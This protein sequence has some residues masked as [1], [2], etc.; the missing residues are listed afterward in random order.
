MVGLRVQSKLFIAIAV[1]IVLFIGVILFVIKP[2]FVEKS[3]EQD[4]AMT[5]DQ[6]ESVSEVFANHRLM[7][8]R[9][10]V[11]WSV[12]TN[13]YDFVQNENDTFVEN[14]MGKETLEN[15]G[16]GA[17]I[18]L[19]KN[20]E[21][22]YSEFNQIYELE[23]AEE[24]SAFT[25]DLLRYVNSSSMTQ[26]AVYGTD[27]GP[28]V[29]MSHPIVKSDGTGEPSGTLVII[30]KIG[31]DFMAAMSA[32]AKTKLSI[33]PLAHQ[34][35]TIEQDSRFA[36][37]SLPLQSIYQ[38][39]NWEVN[40]SVKRTYYTNTQTMLETGMFGLLVLGLGLLLTLFWTV[41]Q[42]ITKRLMG[43]VK[44]LKW[45]TKERNSRLR[46]HLHPHKQDEIEE[47]AISMNEVLD[48]LEQ[49]Q[50]ESLTRAFR[51]S[52]TRLPNRL[53][54]EEMFMN[55]PDTTR[56]IG[57]MGIDLDNFRRIND[58]FGQRTGDAMLTFFASRLMFYKEDGFVARIGADEFILI[59][60]EWTTEELM[61]I[62][63]QLV[64]DLREWG[65]KQG[66]NHLTLSI[67]IDELREPS[68]H[69]YE[70]MMARLDVVLHEVKAS[71]KDNIIS[72]QDI[73]DGSHYLQTLEME[74]DLRH[75]L[76]HDEF[77]LYYQPIVSPQPFQVM[78][79]EALIRWHHPQKG[80]VF[81]GVFIPV[82]EQLGLISDV[83]RWVLVQAITEIQEY[84]E[85]F[86]L[87]LSI[88]VSKRQILDGSFLE[89][90]EE[91][92]TDTGFHPHRLHV[93][94]TESEV[95]GNVYELQQF[96]QAL[97]VIGVKI[98]LDDFGV[99]TSSLSYLQSLRLDIIKIDQNF[100][101]GIPENKFDR[102]LLEG[103]YQTFQTLGLDIVT[104]GVERPEQLAFV[105]EYSSSLIQGY[106]YSKPIPI[107]QLH[108][109]LQK[110]VM[111]Q[112]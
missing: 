82:A 63:N 68:H 39:A 67:G 83:G 98:S 41:N 16:I 66:M 109:Y 37:V 103:L 75:A 79:V 48:A 64:K 60:L 94:I 8:E 22:V 58:Q 44:E 104:E 71:G 77:E 35:L 100:V 59:H 28:V 3:I 17:M 85:R 40:F 25:N 51:D 21:V 70:V 69:S 111:T 9:I 43:I 32:Q 105:L 52:L 95:G 1:N 29:F 107:D 11:D 55:L 91:T 61:I 57:V 76:H 2:Y 53:A 36:R 80:F 73:E 87:F 92:L 96:I 112:I 102:A 10:L 89:T 54:V 78:G 74:R 50:K 99:G 56:S 97:K 81:P 45:I 31:P 86:D 49:T 72:Y 65:L 7:L 34:R 26:S 4:K 46:I 24:K 93:E 90:L 42:I 47:M 23:K 12:W 19:D 18:F 108:H 106:H 101:K 27:F 62:A 84:A 33:S 6:I 88:N 15:L 13:A 14:N 110:T 38:D 20:R 30:Q 5:R